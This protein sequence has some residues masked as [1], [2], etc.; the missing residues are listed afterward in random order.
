MDLSRLQ[1]RSIYPDDRER[2]TIGNFSGADASVYVV[3]YKL[4]GNEPSGFDDSQIKTLQNY[5][6]TIKSGVTRTQSLS[7]EQLKDVEI[8]YDPN[9]TQNT[10]GLG[11]VFTKLANVQTLSFQI[12]REKNPVSGCGSVKPLGYTKGVRR[13][14]G[15]MVFVE[16]AQDTLY[17]LVT[18]NNIRLSLSDRGTRGAYVS[19][20]QVPPLDLIVLFNNEYMSDTGQPKASVLKLFG[21]QFMSESTVLSIHNMFIE[22]TTNF[23]AEDYSPMRNTDYIYSIDEDNP[24]SASDGRISASTA[25]K[26]YDTNR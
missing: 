1:T 18:Q 4:P 9:K 24:A 7:E 5:A 6:S 2:F 17:Q 25:L 20:D 12:F 14:A 22:K 26:F 23:I 15:T 10:S 13:I 19:A 8:V 21:V 3:V 11:I 16:F